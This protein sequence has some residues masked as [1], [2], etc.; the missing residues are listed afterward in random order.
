MTAASKNNPQHQQLQQYLLVAGGIGEQLFAT[1]IMPFLNMT[2]LCTISQVCRFFRHTSQVSFL[3]ETLLDK[4]FT[5]PLLTNR[6]AES[7]AMIIRGSSSDTVPVA[8][9]KYAQRLRERNLRYEQAKQAACR[10]K[11]ER[12]RF[13]RVRRI[14][15]C[16]DV[17]Q[18]RILIPLPI[19][20]IFSSIVVTCLYFDGFNVP[21]WACAAPLLFYFFYLIMSMAV[22]CCVYRQQSNAASVLEGLW[23]D[24]RGPLKAVFS[25]TLRESPKL[26]M[27]GL[28][29]VIICAI[30][31]VM[32]TLKIYLNE[33]LH[34]S[35][36]YLGWAVV[37]I[38]MWLL[39]LA[40]CMAPAIGC[41]RDARANFLPGLLFIWV[42]L[43]IFFICL[44]VKLTARDSHQPMQLRLAL[45][46]V[47][48][49][50]IEGA[51]MLSSLGY[52]LLGLHYYRRGF[53][54]SFCDY[55]GVFASTW[56]L[57]GP[58]V[59]FQALLCARDDGA[60]ATI[61]VSGALTPIL[62]LLG[63]FVIS[64]VAFAVTFPTPFQD[65][66]ENHRREIEGGQAVLFDV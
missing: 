28:A 65:M 46:L 41:F 10:S 44:T 64:S 14:Q 47:P 36:L 54:D 7:D 42:P 18:F 24:M 50:L 1:K 53:L 19:I 5:L 4:D 63:W 25:E 32:V 31:V 48:F 33:Q 40:Y 23:R 52:M 59:C 43:V 51:A 26:A 55:V 11:A 57:L 58:I 34:D 30:Q 62:I 17:T 13:L 2:E 27:Y 37:F 8:K 56:L 49:W 66:R 3:W 38:P 9:E 21:V 60:V 45:I 35:S 22:A 16:L 61:S 12:R 29:I 20:A 6:A 39:F 15:S